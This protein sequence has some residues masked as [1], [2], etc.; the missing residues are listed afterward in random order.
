MLAT[1]AA[2][3]QAQWDPVADDPLSA[4]WTALNTTVGGRLFQGTPFAKPCFGD[5]LTAQCASVRAGYTDEWTRASTPGAW[6]N[7][8]WETC[9]ASGAQCL[10]GD[11]DN[12]GNGSAN[13]SSA[14]CEQG[15]VPLYFIDVREPGDAAAGFQFS[16]D[17]GVP[18]VVKNT[19]HDY[20]GR[21]SAPG[22]LGLWTHNLKNI[23][24]EA[25]FV[26]EGCGEADSVGQAVTAGAQWADGYAFAEENNITLVGGSDRS[27]GMAGGWLQGGGH[28]MLSVSM[29]L[30]VDRV[31]QYKVVTPD[32][33][34]RTANRCQNEDLFWALRGGGGGTFGVVM[35]ATFLASPRVTLQTVTVII[36][37]GDKELSRRLW[38]VMVANGVRWAEEGWGANAVANFAVYVNPKLDKEAAAKSMEPLLNFQ[39]QLESEGHNATVLLV[40]APS[41]GTFFEAFS[42]AHVAAVGNSL[43]LASRLINRDNFATSEDQGALVEALLAADEATPGLIILATAPTAFPSTGN[44]TSVTPLWRESVY[45][46]TVVSPWE[47]DADIQEKQAHYARASASIDNLREITKQGAYSN[48][49]DVNEPNYQT[50]F[51]GDN[52]AELLSIKH[53]YDPEGLLNCWQCVGWNPDD[54]RYRC[55]L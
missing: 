12:V 53:K 55:Y 37:A 46:V 27:V 32:G 40:E 30:G 51:W 25:D 39:K 42:T 43:A 14:S 11:I 13:G 17:T 20:K 38:S 35:E 36:P 8:Q 5:E 34:Y 45:H 2:A 50:S 52:H 47:A 49:A 41:W 48:E 1:F 9:Q 24:L 4:Y 10:L 26:P 23:S 6:I 7:T 21:S 22:S 3:S 28:G 54:A 33:T 29:G 16:R 18:I 15:S 31:L 44:E 19:G